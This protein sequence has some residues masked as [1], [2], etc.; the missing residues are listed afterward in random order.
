MLIF[1]TFESSDAIVAA[2]T[3]DR[4]SSTSPAFSEVLRNAAQGWQSLTRNDFL[5]DLRELFGLAARM[6][7]V[8]V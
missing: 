7:E 2:K 3:C 6:G 5:Q 1:L 4:F 8:K